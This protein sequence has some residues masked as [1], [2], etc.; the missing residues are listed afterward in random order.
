MREIQRCLFHRKVL[1]NKYKFTKK[2]KKNGGLKN[3]KQI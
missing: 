3:A 1:S 2:T